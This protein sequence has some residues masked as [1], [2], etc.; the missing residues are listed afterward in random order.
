MVGRILRNPAV[1]AYEA[2]PVILPY[3][4]A[5]V[6]ASISSASLNCSATMKLT[7]ALRHKVISRFKRSKRCTA[8][9]VI[10]CD[11]GCNVTPTL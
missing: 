4:A 9:I 8:N 7:A 3:F 11:G 5:L 1:T 6:I 2:S 10:A